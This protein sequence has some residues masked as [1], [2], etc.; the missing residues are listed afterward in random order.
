VVDTRSGG[1]GVLRPGNVRSYQVYGSGFRFALQGGRA[2][3]CGI[4]ADALAFEGTVTAVSPGADGFVR[5]WP[6]GL[7]EPNATFL[8]YTR[9]QNISNTGA[10]TLS[11]EF[12]LDLTMR[13]YGGTTHLV[14]DVQG[15]FVNIGPI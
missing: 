8:N 4:P 7:P 14:V 3:G 1:G 5:A 9:N 13:N 2:G 6:T 10:I 11:E 12:E 15:Y